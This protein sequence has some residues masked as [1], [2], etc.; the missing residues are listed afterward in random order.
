MTTRRKFGM[1]IAAIIAAQRA[2]A[3]LIRS[4]IAGRHI[5]ATGTRL[6]YD[7]EV[8]YL[9]SNANGYI[10]TGKAVSDKTE[11][12]FWFNADQSAN[13]YIPI[14]GVYRRDGYLGCQISYGGGPSRILA[15]RGTSTKSIF[16]ETKSLDQCTGVIELKNGQWGMNG[17][18]KSF[19]S[20]MF[21]ST[22]T[23]WF[24]RVNGIG[25]FGAVRKFGYLKMWENGTMVFN[26]IPVR[27][28]NEQGVSEG[29]MYD[30]VSG[31]LF[32]NAGTGAF[33]IGP[34]KARGALAQNGGGYKWII[35]A[36]DSGPSWRP[37]LQRWRQSP[38]S[39]R[40]AA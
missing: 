38:S 37:H 30:R 10:D 12:E 22:S 21:Q 25:N 31:Q 14:F 18:F 32:R 2:P 27:F 1:G 7:A 34:V 28:T 29:A 40:E 3:A 39:W 19:P 24:N 20:S 9:Q 5:A 33:V 4:L 15:W 26:A 13:T 16:I 35:I 36:S 23:A 6:P 8:E 11:V 17:T